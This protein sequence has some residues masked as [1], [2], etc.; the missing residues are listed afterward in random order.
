L[1][2]IDLFL[3]NLEFVR[4]HR[5]YDDVVQCEVS[6]LPFKDDSYDTVIASEVLEHLEKERGSECLREFERVSS[7]KVI[8]LTPQHP[9]EREGFATS[10]GFNPYEA[11]VSKWSLDEL[12]SLGYRVYGAG[13]R[14]SHLFGKYQVAVDLVAGFFFYKFPQLAGTFIAVKRLVKRRK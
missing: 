8:L 4:N 3:P 11:H 9:G 1:V 7:K 6:R 10:V 13:F 5:V 12:R 2:G 14:F